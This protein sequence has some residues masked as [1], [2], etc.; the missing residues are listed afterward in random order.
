MLLNKIAKK[1]IYINLK[2]ILIH[3]VSRMFRSITEDDENDYQ[4]ICSVV[5]MINSSSVLGT[6][7]R[8]GEQSEHFHEDLQNC[9]SGIFSGLQ[10]AVCAVWCSET[11][12][13]ITLRPEPLISSVPEED[14]SI[15]I[16]ED[17][18]WLSKA[19][20]ILWD[21]GRKYF[22]FFET[23]SRPF[24]PSPPL[25]PDTDD[26]MSFYLDY[27][28]EYDAHAPKPIPVPKERPYRHRRRREPC[29]QCECTDCFL[30]GP[31]CI[32]DKCNQM[33][34]N[35]IFNLET[36]TFNGSKNI[37]FGEMGPDDLHFILQ[38]GQYTITCYVPEDLFRSNGDKYLATYV[39]PPFEGDTF[40]GLERFYNMDEATEAIVGLLE[41]IASSSQFLPPAPA[42]GPAPA[43][44]PEP[45]SAP[46]P[47]PASAPV[48][49]PASAPAP[50]PAPVPAPAPAPKASRK[51]PSS[52]TMC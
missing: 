11:I 27:N 37:V 29:D 18:Q 4:N 9:I 50:A 13:F 12:C 26:S 51:A 48:P 17:G 8:L 44:V 31:S 33:T 3:P 52:C 6:A 10:S 5:R 7:F 24:T 42:P 21:L 19:E 2:L 45:A 14:L 15:V 20:A 1:C 22:E 39:E 49:E 32:R 35:I 41:R 38:W 28:K 47:E 16:D 30:P 43:P 34:I 40:L 36:T 46:A 23:E 25:S